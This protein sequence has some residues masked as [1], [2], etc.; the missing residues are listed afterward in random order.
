MRRR[1]KGTAPSE[2]EPFDEAAVVFAGTIGTPEDAEGLSVEIS[3]S[4]GEIVLRS[5]AAEIG[6]WSLE[7]VT[8]RRTDATSFAFTAE[9]DRLSFRPEDPD[10]FG[11]S[12]LVTPEEVEGRR[13]KFRKA[14]KSTESPPTDVVPDLPAA[15]EVED[16]RRKR[17]KRRRPAKSTEA[18]QANI[19]QPES[20]SGPARRGPWIW[21]LDMA[22]RHDLLGLDRVPV[23]E[24]LRGGTHQHTWDDRVA[25]SSGLSSHVCTMCGK[26]RL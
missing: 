2:G 17:R 14:A 22:R 10:L 18:T 25:A 4:G 16:G 11:S 6:R 3:R 7:D 24:R 26:I 21:L 23:D 12:P 19:D 15:N 1:G 8:I 20:T 13:R 5:E 9:E